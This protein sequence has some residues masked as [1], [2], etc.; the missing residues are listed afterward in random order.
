M[1]L[2]LQGD[3]SLFKCALLEAR[4]KAGIESFCFEYKAWMNFG[5]GRSSL[6]PLRGMEGKTIYN[7]LF[8]GISQAEDKD[9]RL[10]EV[11]EILKIMWHYSVPECPDMYLLQNTINYFGYEFGLEA[12]N[13]GVSPLEK[14]GTILELAFDDLVKGK[15]GVLEFIRAVIS[16]PLMTGELQKSRNPLA[17][18][19]RRYDGSP[20]A[21][22]VLQLLIDG[23][24][25][26]S[27]EVMD[28]WSIYSFN[29]HKAYL[30]GFADLVHAIPNPYILDDNGEGFQDVIEGI[31]KMSA[32][33]SNG[34]GRVEERKNFC[35]QALIEARSKRS[36]V[37]SPAGR[38]VTLKLRSS[39]STVFITG[40]FDS[41]K[42]TIQMTR[43]EDGIYYK[44]FVFEIDKTYQ[45][46]F[47]ADGEW[48]AS[49]EYFK[50]D[51]GHGNIN[52][53]I[54]TL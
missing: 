6:N 38:P 28:F 53:V 26:I 54:M 48:I 13:A 31:Y 20:D 8:E 37:F 5:C 23:G 36:A 47:V 19:A 10:L 50:V 49:G 16:H 17:S 4:E 32:C 39:A 21:K 30:D 45:F 33:G 44:H 52:N 41:W 42:R 12:L 3:P 2:G 24:A 35:Y 22:E 1:Q 7:A 46:K 43:A 11:K 27:R 14:Y 25:K 34:E 51:D 18:F 40:T 29:I 9:Q 15:Q